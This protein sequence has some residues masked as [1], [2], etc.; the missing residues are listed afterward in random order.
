MQIKPTVMMMQ[1]RAD[2]ASAEKKLASA[3]TS[4]ASLNSK[5]VYLKQCNKDLLKTIKKYENICLEHGVL[6]YK[7]SRD[8]CLCMCSN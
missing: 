7:S 4:N 5:Y 2:Q 6:S 8:D 3:L 1:V